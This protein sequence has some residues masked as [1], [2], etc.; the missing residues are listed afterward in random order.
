VSDITDGHP[1]SEDIQPQ[2]FALGHMSA[3]FEP[4]TNTHTHTH[5]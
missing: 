3:V 1:V 2:C 4:A 5:I